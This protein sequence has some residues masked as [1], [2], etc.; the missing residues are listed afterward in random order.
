MHVEL[1]FSNVQKYNDNS[2][3]FFDPAKKNG[4]D[5]LTVCVCLFVWTSGGEDD[6]ADDDDD[7]D[8]DHDDD[9]LW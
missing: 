6:D 4:K 8:D 9:K 7:D 3:F 5:L 2:T 1:A